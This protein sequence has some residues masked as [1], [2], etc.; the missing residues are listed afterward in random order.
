MGDHSMGLPYIA[1]TRGPNQTMKNRGFHTQKPGLL[2]GKTR[3]WML[4]GAP[5]IG[6]VPT[7]GFGA[8]YMPHMESLGFPWVDLL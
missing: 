8:A 5:G 4:Y 1:Y 6:V 3:F 7:K 2:L